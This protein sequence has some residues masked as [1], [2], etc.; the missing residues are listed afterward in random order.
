MATKLRMK[1]KR[2]AYELPYGNNR[3][4]HFA[5]V[6]DMPELLILRVWKSKEPE[7][8]GFPYT[9]DLVGKGNWEPFGFA[10]TKLDAQLAA[11]KKALELLRTAL[12]SFLKGPG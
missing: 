2:V 7:V 5:Y 10:K 12:R 6:G 11:E 9:W 1:W 3:G 8:E 4:G